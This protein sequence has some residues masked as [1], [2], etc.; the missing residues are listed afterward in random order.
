MLAVLAAFSIQGYAPRVPDADKLTPADPS[1]I[2]NAIAYALRCPAGVS[3]AYGTRRRYTA[4]AEGQIQ[5]KPDDVKPFANAG[6]TPIS[7]DTS[8][9]LSDVALELDT[10]VRGRQRPDLTYHLLRCA[11]DQIRLHPAGLADDP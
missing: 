2:A 1:D 7:V 9:R 3:T 8:R 4:D 5:V 11:D 10:P 6:F